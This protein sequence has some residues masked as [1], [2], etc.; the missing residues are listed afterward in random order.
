MEKNFI[1]QYE[2]EFPNE[3][4]SDL[5][6]QVGEIMEI[7]TNLA[8]ETKFENIQDFESESEIIRIMTKLENPSN[9]ILVKFSKVDW[10]YAIVIRCNQS[11]HREEYVYNEIMRKKDKFSE[12]EI[13]FSQRYIYKLRSGNWPPQDWKGFEE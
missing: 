4:T 9:F 1:V 2:L 7:P 8:R 13:L 3:Y 5:V 10:Y 6:K 11:V 12:E